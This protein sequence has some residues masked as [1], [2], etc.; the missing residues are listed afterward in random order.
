MAASRIISNCCFMKPSL[1][2]S[3]VPLPARKSSTPLLSAVLTHHSLVKKVNESE[4]ATIR[5]LRK[6]DRFGRLFHKGNAFFSGGTKSVV[7]GMADVIK[8]CSCCQLFYEWRASYPEYLVL[9]EEPRHGE[10]LECFSSVSQGVLE[11]VL[12]A[13]KRARHIGSALP[14]C[15]I[16]KLH[17]FL[18]RAYGNKDVYKTG[19]I[20]ALAVKEVVLESLPF[21]IGNIGA[22]HSAANYGYGAAQR[23]RGIGCIHRR[24][25]VLILPTVWALYF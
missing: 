11:G 6:G 2:G 13:K 3:I 9:V 18:I 17:L 20:R 16:G 1:L 25:A 5:T 24:S 21:N 12:I 19:L 8:G 22:L 14:N 7:V 4:L 10:K 15:G 23:I